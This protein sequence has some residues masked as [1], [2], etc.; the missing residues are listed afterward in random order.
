MISE[1]TKKTNAERT[2]RKLS[3]VY[4]VPIFI[5]L[6][7]SGC[8]SVEPFSYSPSF[9]AQVVDK[10]GKP[11]PG[12]YI[13]YDYAGEE[14]AIV[15]RSSYVLEAAI[16]VTDQ[17]GRFKVPSLFQTHSLFKTGAKMAV[18]PGYCPTTHSMFVPDFKTH[19]IVPPDNSNNPKAWADDL[20]AFRWRYSCWGEHYPRSRDFT[21]TKKDSG[22]F[23]MPCLNQ[24]SSFLKRK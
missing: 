24:N 7:L 12:I 5:V 3:I 22:R 19:K 23:L 6:L 18:W 17:N 11:L 2:K 4:L 9:S 13:L 16:L 1:Q 8:L 10:N 14:S 15:E 21:C 20:K